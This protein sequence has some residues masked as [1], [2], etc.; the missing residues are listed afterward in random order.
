MIRKE[1]GKYN[2]YSETGDKHLGGP[3]NSEEEAQKRLKQIEF[4]KH[5]TKNDK[6]PNE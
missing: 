3:Y 1:N 4:F 6:K 2:V 5:F